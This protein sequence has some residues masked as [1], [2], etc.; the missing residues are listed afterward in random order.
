[1]QSK[2]IEEEFYN[3]DTVNLK[4]GRGYRLKHNKWQCNLT[5]R[6]SSLSAALPGRIDKFIE[7]P[8]SVVNFIT[9]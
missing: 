8:T 2:V 7:K 1:M 5:W 4:V 6:R 9:S 3:E